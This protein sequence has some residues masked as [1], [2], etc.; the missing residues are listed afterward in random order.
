[1][2]NTIQFYIK[3][4]WIFI[5]TGDRRA[6]TNSLWIVKDNVNKYIFES[7]LYFMIQLNNISP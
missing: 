3:S 6:G 7:I 4:P 1:M 5:S 2:Q